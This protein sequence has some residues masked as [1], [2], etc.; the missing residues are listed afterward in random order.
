MDDNSPP[1][2]IG[3]KSD[4]GSKQATE[5][6]APIAQE[7]LSVHSRVVETGRVQIKKQSSQH[8]EIV[9]EP[10]LREQVAIE[11]VPINRVC[12]GPA[13]SSR[14]V[15]E[16]FVIPILEEVLMVEKRLMLKEELHVSRVRNIVHEPQTVVL[17]SEN[18]TM[19]R[20]EPSAA[21]DEN[22]TSVS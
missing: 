6:V 13:P 19:E 17:R 12:E 15:G 14:Y 3:S 21:A 20:I 22:D 9:D 10:I 4:P 16:V 18:V 5:V 7:E 8:E 11:R 1:A 2:V